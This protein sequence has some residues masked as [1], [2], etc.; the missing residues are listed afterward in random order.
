MNKPLSLLAQLTGGGGGN[1]LLILTVAFPLLV[2]E[3]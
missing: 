3:C 2:W 1:S